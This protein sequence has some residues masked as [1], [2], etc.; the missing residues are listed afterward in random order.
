MPAPYLDVPL[1]G[2]EQEDMQE[3][4]AAWAAR[5]ASIAYL[6]ADD[7]CKGLDKYPEDWKAADVSYLDQLV[8]VLW[9]QRRRMIDENILKQKDCYDAAP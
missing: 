2:S 3:Q 4:A 5:Q 7:L 9:E 6:L 8:E 1:L